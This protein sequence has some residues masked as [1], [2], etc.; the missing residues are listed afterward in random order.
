MAPRISHGPMSRMLSA[1]TRSRRPRRLAVHSPAANAS[2]I[3]T[4]YQWTGSGPKLNAIGCTACNLAAK[5]E[6]GKPKRVC[7]LSEI[8]PDPER[9]KSCDL[10]SRQH[11]HSAAG[12]L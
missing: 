4:P 12:K 1:G 2:A 9:E 8:K 11:Y 6:R 3:I 7:R 5:L 10:A